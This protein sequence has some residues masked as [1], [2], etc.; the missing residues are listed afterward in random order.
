[1]PT[2]RSTKTILAT[3]ATLLACGVATTTAQ[4]DAPSLAVQGNK[5]VNT[6]T[7]QV[8][9]PRGVNWPSFEYACA[10]GYG[11]SNSAS[12][13]Q[14]GPTDANAALLASWHVNVVRIPLNQSCWSGDNG[15]PRHDNTDEDLDSGGYR[16]AVSDWVK[17]LHDHGIATIL[18]LHWSAPHNAEAIGQRA[19][20]DNLSD[21]FWQSVATRFKDDRS[22]IFDAFN[23]PYSK[24]ADDPHPF[25]LTWSCWRD[26]G[27]DAPNQND[28]GGPD[29]GT[30]RV[31]GMQQLVN[32]IRGAGATQPIMIAG[33]DYANDL[34]QWLKNKP[35]DNQLVASFHNYETQRCSTVACWDAEIAP[36]AASVPVVAGEFGESDC[37]SDHDVSFMN[38]ADQHG[39][40][41]LMW[42]WVVLEAGEKAN[43][44]CASLQIISDTKG[45]PAAPN[46]TAFKAHLDA[47]AG[48]RPAPVVTTGATATPAP[49]TTPASQ[50]LPTQ[51]LRT[52][53][54]ESGSF[55]AP[56]L[57]DMSV[58]RSHGKLVL[59][60]TTSRDASVSMK[61]QRRSGR[62]LVTIVTAKRRVRRGFNTVTVTRHHLR[63]GSYRV[64]V[65]ATD[66]AGHRSASQVVSFTVR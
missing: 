65:S 5:L 2:M 9:Q 4:A 19:M 17:K 49:K 26:G 62:R 6:D 14:V 29:T 43:P 66:K 64:S 60:V 59:D 44:E 27:C 63:S 18:D 33:L 11:Y 23:E 3:A 37:K 55:L 52:P 54:R 7:N 51:T 48:G 22:M 53:A 15:Y 56:R 25:E 42:Q 39:V 24:A 38:W 20:A 21:D 58:R 10:Y 31:T 35:K 46:G 36:I 50:T 47:L 32:A 45:T 28:D 61:L 8:F 40:G 30:F 41:Y 12:E 57:R 34:S 16:D 13:T 1:M